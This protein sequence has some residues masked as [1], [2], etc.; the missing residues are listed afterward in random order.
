M[1]FSTFST[2]MKKC[3]DTIALCDQPYSEPTKIDMF[4][5]RIKSNNSDLSSV[6]VLLRTNTEKCNTFIKVHQELAKH[7]AI[8]FPTSSFNGSGKHP[9]KRKVSATNATTRNKSHKIVTK[10][11]IKYCNNIDVTD[12]T[13]SFTS[14]EWKALPYSFKEV[15]FKDPNRKKRKTTDNRTSSDVTTKNSTLNDETLGRIISGVA[16]ATL[17]QG[18]GNGPPTVIPPRMGAGGATQRQTGAV[19]TNSSSGASVITND[20]RWDHNGNIIT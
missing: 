18:D 6:I 11:G 5:R 10:D 19:S 9:H 1:S 7:V 15:L 14:K 13:R 2:K 20:T 16:R 12:Q 17:A 3:F 4:L 8:L